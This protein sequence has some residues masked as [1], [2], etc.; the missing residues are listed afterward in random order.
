MKDEEFKWITLVDNQKIT[1]NGIR[2]TKVTIRKLTKTPDEISKE[3]E[4][5][6]EANLTK[7]GPT[8]TDRRVL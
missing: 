8:L 7:Y 4:L 2:S 3:M 6:A 1:L 5:A